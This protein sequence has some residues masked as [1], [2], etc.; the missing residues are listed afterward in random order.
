MLVRQ[1][2]QYELFEVIIHGRL[3]TCASNLLQIPQS[4][5]SLIRCETVPSDQSPWQTKSI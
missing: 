1:A 4:G 3:L 2:Q 5:D